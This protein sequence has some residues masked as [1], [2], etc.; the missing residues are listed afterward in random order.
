MSA[1][2]PIP[3]RRRTQDAAGLALVL[4]LACWVRVARF[5]RPLAGGELLAI[6][7][8][9]HHHVRRIQG[10]LRG[11]LPTFDPLVNWP[12]GGIAPWTDGFDRLGAAFAWVAGGGHSGPRAEM[13]I[14]LWPV[15]LGILAVWAT[16]DVARRLVPAGDQ[17]TPLAAGLVAA[18]VPQ[19]VQISSFG[20]VDH[21]IAEALS[22]LL[23]LSWALRRFPVGEEAR[24]GLAWEGTGALA[25]VFALW[26]FIGGELYV[27][28]VALPLGLAAMGMDP[29]RR[30]TG[31]GAPA[32]LG[33]ALLG[34][35]AS[36]PA[37]SVHGKVFSF[38]LPSMV[39]PGLVGIAGLALS[40]MVLVGRV[41]SRPGRRAFPVIQIGAALAVAAL[42]L[43]LVPALRHELARAIHG[44]LMA[45]DPWIAQIA[46]FQPIVRL[47]PRGGL[48]LKP[49]L[50]LLG[51]F[52]FL[53]VPALPFA[54]AVAWRLSPARAGL[55]AWTVTSLSVLAFSQLRF[56]RVAAPLLAVALALALRGV[57]A[58]LGR[59]PVLARLA[60][61]APLLATALLVAGNSGLRTLLAIAEPRTP[62][63][64]HQVALALRLDRPPVPGHRD[65][66]LAPWDLG[67][68]LQQVSGR[69]VV[70]NGFGTYL[71]PDSFREVQDAFLGDEQ[72]LVRTMEERDLGFALGGGHAIARHQ[73]Q[74]GEEGIVEGDP[75]VLN[76]RYMR[77]TPLSQLLIAGSGLPSVG[78]P[79]LER[80]MPVA[81]SE[82]VAEKLSFPLPVVWAYE[83]VPGARVVGQGD[84]GG[85]VAG[86]IEFHEWGRPHRY[87]AWTRADGAGRWELR[88][89]VP[90][91][92][93]THTIRT[94][95]A[96]RITQG[97]GRVVDVAVP[98]TAVRGGLAIPLP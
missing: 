69:P 6:D 39:Q 31:S 18:F 11:A 92:F 28:L 29:K 43:A 63:P 45:K 97:D 58:W 59:A 70:A 41:P 76:L 5:A 27:A 57:S 67:H 33:G 26:V 85:L 83:L 56:T 75:P 86:E 90:S 3:V 19:F 38:A 68:A 9:S 84:P 79:H 77:G 16:V 4:G 64:V 37:L 10:A 48:D 17:A 80:L 40:T 25:V 49:V 73:A 1:R 50:D 62:S 65:G 22:V 12:E 52:G 55:F 2:G 60:G 71:D 98:E 13:A 34:A 89:A 81:A 82:V 91:G 78:V 21:H 88:V 61:P 74:P 36:L 8:D 32:L 93:S 94:G 23:L 66:V 20:N 96:W 24:P 35:V 87:R 14:F 46:E 54:V 42:P 15:V 30:L 7:G 47:D 95:P 53:A 51:P 44:W 72:G